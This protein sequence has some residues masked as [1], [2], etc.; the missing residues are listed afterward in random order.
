MKKII[1]CLL[2]SIAMVS[3]Y[4]DYIKDFTYSGIYFPYQVD[5]RSFI[6]GEGMKIDV[7]VTLGG[8]I[9]NTK[10]RNVSF[11]FD[12]TLINAS[13]LNKMKTSPSAYI[14]NPVTS[15]ST[16]LAL[17]ASYYTLSNTST[18]VIKA[19]QHSGR[20]TV[21]VDSAAFLADNLTIIPNYVL[22]FRITA[23]DADSVVKLKSYAVVGVKYENMLFGNYW[24]G[25]ITTVDSAGVTVKPI[26]YYTTIPQPDN[27]VWTLTTVAPN[28]LVSNG[29]A[30]QTTT[31]QEVKLTLSGGNITISA[32]TGSTNAYQ[33]D[34]A[35]TYNQAKLLQNRKIVL[36][37]KYVIGVKTFHAQ[38]TLTFRNRIQDGVNVWMDEDPT[39]YK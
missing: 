31:K 19:G 33:P 9:E 8:V 23:A 5:V 22:P 6:V 3:C 28:A 29:Y 12:N 15:I 21:A 35:S 10:D 26:R 39:H 34:G 13:I 37:Y 24:H 1:F 18:I 20:V 17:P 27:K 38:D 2:L 16:L 11:T 14:K 25:G 36:S 32:G 7:G 30:D 4:D